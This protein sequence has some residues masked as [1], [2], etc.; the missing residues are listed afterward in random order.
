MSVQP[1][2]QVPGPQRAAPGAENGPQANAAQSLP[3]PL[4][5]LGGLGQAIAKALGI[6]GGDQSS[7]PNPMQ[8]AANDPRVRGRP[9][10]QLQIP[11]PNVG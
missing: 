11:P 2:A 4:N 7:G 8:T 3:F 5:L 10:H 1:A 9:P 6:G